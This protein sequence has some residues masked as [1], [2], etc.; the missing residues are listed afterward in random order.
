MRNSDD[1]W[2]WMVVAPLWTASLWR[3]RI[4]IQ[5]PEARILWYVITSL[6][7]A[8]T[9]RLSPVSDTIFRVTRVDDCATLVKHLVGVLAI[10]MLLR[11]VLAVI[12][13]R[14]DGQPE[15]RYRRVI[16]SRPRRVLTGAALITMTGVFP[17]SNRR[18]GRADD[19][20][21][22]YAQAGH[23]WGSVHL[24]L[25]YTYLAFGLSCSAI[26]CAE[27]YRRDRHQHGTPSV[28]GA[29]M[30]T[31]SIGC[32]IGTS[33]GIIRT[34]YLIVRLARRAFVGGDPLVVVISNGALISCIML[35]AFGCSAPTIERLNNA[36]AMHES[37]AAL[38]PMWLRLTAVT[39]SVVLDPHANS[40]TTGSFRIVQPPNPRRAAVRRRFKR[41]MHPF[42]SR[43]RY[44]R[45]RELLL[46]V[47]E[48]ANWRQLDYRL[49]RRVIEICDAIM[50]LQAYIPEDLA[51]QAEAVVAERKLSAQALPAFLIYTAIGRKRA[52]QPKTEDHR[53]MIIRLEDDYR[54]AATV[55]LLPVW[56]QMRNRS[57]ISQLR[58]HTSSAGVS[59]R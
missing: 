10:A 17:W 38:R 56:Q 33:Y 9:T 1:L 44:R 26:M 28:L 50:E 57:A 20:T 23:L 52:G 21:F 14:Q 39:P 24:I 59:A 19:S 46:M 55:T 32:S 22:I 15:P 29:G 11:W 7:V 34:A 16:S 8:M 47:A 6:A 49:M 45:W 37:I 12:P 18:P 58:R 2:S 51:D 48:F 27:A 13:A 36:Q 35:I 30:G 25:F 54:R 40:E 41:I 43:K 4:A 31:M 53:H 5:R 42:A 3:L